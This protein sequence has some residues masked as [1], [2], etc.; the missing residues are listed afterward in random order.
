SLPPSADSMAAHSGARS[1]DPI[2]AV[3]YDFDGTLADTTELLL[4]SYRHTMGIFLAEVP[5][6]EEWT[7][8]FGTTLEAQMDRFAESPA[9]ASAMIDVYRR[10]QRE[11]HDALI[12]RFPETTT[13]L[14]E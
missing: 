1:A 9:Q 7:K 10:F 8:G 5:P 2:T 11:H 3:L 14:G 4:Q 6:D 13:V 12:R